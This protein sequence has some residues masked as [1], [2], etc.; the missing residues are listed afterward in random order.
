[1]RGVHGGQEI[2]G[3]SRMMPAKQ[4]QMALRD[5]IPCVGSGGEWGLGRELHGCFLPK[6]ET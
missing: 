2:S 5:T 4:R 3:D 6:P 1:M